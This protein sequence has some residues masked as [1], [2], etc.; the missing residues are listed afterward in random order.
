MNLQIYDSIVT[1]IEVRID[2]VWVALESDTFVEQ[3]GSNR[4]DLVFEGC[5]GTQLSLSSGNKSQ[6][7]KSF[8][9]E[10]LCGSSIVR[11]YCFIF[12]SESDALEITAKGL[13][14]ELQDSTAINH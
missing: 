2:S 7:L 14:V 6:R 9:V 11:R 10:P 4:I 8:Y 12:T 13:R 1:G 5:V 3:L